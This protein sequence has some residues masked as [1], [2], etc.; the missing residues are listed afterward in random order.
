MICSLVSPI[1][2]V[3]IAVQSVCVRDGR[4]EPFGPPSDADPSRRDRV[5]LQET[6]D[7][8]LVESALA[9]QKRRSSRHEHNIIVTSTRAGRGVVV[10]SRI[11]RQ[12]SVVHE[13]ARVTAAVKVENFHVE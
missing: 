6:R 5:A 8:A 10:L 4:A 9:G 13:I 11:Y 3:Q 1:D 7:V 2:A 12:L